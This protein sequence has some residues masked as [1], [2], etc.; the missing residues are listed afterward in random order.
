ME[1]FC[2]LVIHSITNP[3]DFKGY[4][5]LKFDFELLLR[6]LP[7]AS[8]ELLYPPTGFLNGEPSQ[9]VIVN[10]TGFSREEEIFRYL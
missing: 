6:R 3:W 5:I 1:L 8:F 10:D 7:D 9:T 4:P 2:P